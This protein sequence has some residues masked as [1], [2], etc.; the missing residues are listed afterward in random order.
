MEMVGYVPG[1]VDHMLLESPPWD[2]CFAGELQ[3]TDKW[4]ELNQTHWTQTLKRI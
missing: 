1:K 2:D 3:G 4:L